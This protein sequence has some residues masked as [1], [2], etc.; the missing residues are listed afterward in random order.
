M[1]DKD[2]YAPRWVRNEWM[3]DHPNLVWMDLGASGTLHLAG[4]KEITEEYL[5]DNNIDIVVSL[6]QHPSHIFHLLASHTNGPVHHW[7]PFADDRPNKQP[8][9]AAQNA[10]DAVRA[11]TDGLIAGQ[12]ILVHCRAGMHRSAAVVYAA[13]VESGKFRDVYEAY[14]HVR[15]FRAVARYYK[16]L[17]KWVQL[18]YRQRYSHG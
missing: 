15:K 1:T 2:D 8:E 18:Q 16:T 3:P 4:E 10:A 7:L 17:V 5:H 9:G 14:N 6:N 11:V 13:L 12:N